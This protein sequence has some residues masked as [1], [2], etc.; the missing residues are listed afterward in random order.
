MQKIISIVKNKIYDNIQLNQ[1]IIL[2]LVLLIWI[3]LYG[4]NMNYLKVFII[5]ST[6]IITDLFFNRY[7]FWK[8]IFPF[9]W[10]NAWFW[11]S[12][13]LRTDEL[14]I[15]FF[16]WFLAIIWKNLLTIRWKHF[17]NPS[18]MWVVI[19]L[20]FFPHYTWVNTLQWWNYT[21]KLTAEYILIITLLLIFW[22]LITYRVYKVFKYNYFKDYLLPFFILHILLFFIIV[23]NSS[24]PLAL[25]FFSP[26]FFIFMFHMMS[27][28]KTV[29]KKSI[30]RFLYSISIVLTFYVLQF[31]MN[32]GYSMVFALF[33]NT[34]ILPLVWFFED[35]N[36]NNNFSLILLLTLIFFMATYIYLSV[37]EKWNPIFFFDNICSQIF[38]K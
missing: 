3:E 37:I 35:K 6:V 16:A 36:N 34:L 33:I 21:W 9:S 5:F 24:V 10:V 17:M 13:F 15:Y 26:S 27:D 2:S 11:I 30:N 32:E 20:L 7:K 18:N 23:W 12:F 29:P 4:I 28:P 25:M 38:C 1:T 14:L 22:S 19:S 31:N 8:W